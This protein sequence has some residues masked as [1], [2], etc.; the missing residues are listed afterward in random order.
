MTNCFLD[1]KITQKSE[2][3]SNL[4]QTLLKSIKETFYRT[5]DFVLLWLYCK[6]WG[7]NADHMLSEN[8]FWKF[9]R[10]HLRKV[11]LDFC[12]QDPD[13]TKPTGWPSELLLLVKTRLVQ[14]K[15]NSAE[16]AN[17]IFKE[18]IE[19]NIP[20]GKSDIVIMVI[21]KICRKNKLDYNK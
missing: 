15:V 21:N 18:S 4:Y 13:E 19:T 5:E 8:D 11:L 3:E 17:T 10:D 12:L 9:N 2:F 16:W 6:T 20:K 7:V 1:G 14:D